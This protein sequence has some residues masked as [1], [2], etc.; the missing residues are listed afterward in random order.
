[1]TDGRFGKFG[2]SYVPE[3]LIPALQTLTQAWKQLAHD[4]SFWSEFAGLLRD[5]VGRPTPLYFAQRMTRLLGGPQ[6]YLKREDLCHTGAH[7]INNAL[8]Q[9]L[10]AKRLGKKRVVAETGAGQHGVAIASACALL[11][12]QCDVFMGE[13]DI[14]RQA[15][16]VQR[17]RMLGA[18]LRP[19]SIGSKTLKDAL[20]E[21]LR[22]WVTNVETTH[23]CLGSVA[24]PHPY[25]T[26]VRELQSVI[27][28]E[29][30]RQSI[31]QFQALPSALIACVGGGSN[32]MGLF[33]E[34]ISEST[35]RLIGVEA[36]HSASLAQG[37]DGVLH[38][39]RSLILQ[40]QDGQVLE[41]HSIAPGLDYPGVG[42]ELAHLKESGRLQVVSANDREARRAFEFLART[43][44]II[45]ALE[46]SHAIAWVRRAARE[47]Q[48]S[49]QWVI[50]ISGRGDKDLAALEALKP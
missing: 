4:Q 40:D 14:K 33:S 13:E 43:E 29:V 26:L 9:A 46:S 27:G 35:V 23:Y 10:I 19:V 21:A 28:R 6:I 16:N 34:F 20:N 48:S 44:G 38:G 37:S 45:P 30:R 49:D 5:F 24:G 7:K 3:T 8:G 32:A 17:M 41:A 47:F 22:D 15:P 18:T 36:Q 25:P 2:G 50:N 1:M 12:L 31:E 39:S 11:D 42:P